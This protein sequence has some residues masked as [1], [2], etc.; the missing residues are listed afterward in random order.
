MVK[1]MEKGVLS[2]A[3]FS[4][5]AQS[6]LPGSQIEYN[7]DQGGK[8][9]VVLI[10]YIVL[11]LAVATLVVF[12]GRWVYHKVSNN[13]GPTPVSVAPQGTSQ[14]TQSSPSPTSPAPSPSTSPSPS[15]SSNSGSSSGKSS[16]SGSGSSSSGSTNQTKTQTKTTSPTPSSLPNN[17]PGEAILVFIA[18]SFTAALMH[19]VATTYKTAKHI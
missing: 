8:R 2:M 12:A 19:Y 10:V 4:N 15:A 3:L 11:A 9:W 7:N 14:G 18:V 17:G 1:C 16:G 13:A 6:E 5:N